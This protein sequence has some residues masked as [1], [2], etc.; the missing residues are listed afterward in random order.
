MQNKFESEGGDAISEDDT[1]NMS[2]FVQE[3]IPMIRASSK[4]ADKAYQTNPFTASVLATLANTVLNMLKKKTI[5]TLQRNY[6]ATV[7]TGAA[8]TFD[9]VDPVGVFHKSSPINIKDIIKI[10]QKE[11]PNQPQLLG[12][13]HFSSKTFRTAPAHIQEMFE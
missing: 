11:F 12:A 8:L 13:L 3:H 5:S 9:R 1:N 6:A 7:M 10:L 2:N 4:G